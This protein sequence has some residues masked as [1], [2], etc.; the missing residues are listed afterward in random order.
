MTDNEKIFDEFAAYCK[1]RDI[2]VVLAMDDGDRYFTLI[3]GEKLQVHNLLT[4]AIKNHTES[5]NLTM[6]E[7]LT[8]VAIAAA[9]KETDYKIPAATDLITTLVAKHL[10]VAEQLWGKKP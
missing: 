3:S 2:P 7:L 5:N 8:H 9:M 4:Q 10:L 6:S 1:K